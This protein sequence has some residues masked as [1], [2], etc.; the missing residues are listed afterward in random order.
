MGE[1]LVSQAAHD[2]RYR[3]IA[4]QRTRLA[5]SIKRMRWE[6]ANPTTTNGSRNDV[7]C[8]DMIMNTTM[9][10]RMRVIFFEASSS[11]VRGRSSGSEPGCAA[12]GWPTR[13]PLGA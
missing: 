13:H 3:P 7:N 9:M 1:D 6:T 5:S 8:D 11:E 12:Q 2:P 4:A 10:D